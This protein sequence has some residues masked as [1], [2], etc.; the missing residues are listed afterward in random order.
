MVTKILGYLFS[1]ISLVLLLSLSH[2][3]LN[4]NESNLTNI[5]SI[6]EESWRVSPQRKQWP[7]TVFINSSH[8]GYY[9]TQEMRSKVYSPSS[10]RQYITLTGGWENI[11]QDKNWSD[12]YLLG[13]SSCVWAVSFHNSHVIRQLKK[14][15]T[16]I[17]P[18]EGYSSE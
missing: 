6:S 10:L 18:W 8:P 4:C 9:L 14:V 12:I 17:L 13:V 3:P 15:F 5:Q 7:C 1:F 11:F 16:K 2:F